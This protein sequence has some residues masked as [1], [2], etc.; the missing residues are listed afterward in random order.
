MRYRNPA[1]SMDTD[2][3]TETEFVH[4]VWASEYGNQVTRISRSGLRA[5]SGWALLE[6]IA[7]GMLTP[8]EM[9]ENTTLQGGSTALLQHLRC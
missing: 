7:A 8:S 4:I 5:R 3:D 1:V 2:G 6:D 9:A